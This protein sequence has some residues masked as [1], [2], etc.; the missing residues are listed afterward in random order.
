[1]TL[2]ARALTVGDAPR[3]VDIINHIISVGGSTA[4]ETPFTTDY[5]CTHY[6]DGPPVANA[7][8]SNGRVVGFQ[9]AF[10][11]APGFYSVATFTD[12]LTPCPGAGRAL[13]QKTLADCRAW[14]GE[15][16]LAKIT[17]DNTGGLA[18]YSKMGF[19]D[20]TVDPNAL[21]R[22]NGTTV[23]RVIKRFDL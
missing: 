15:A 19:K 7:V 22:Q 1:M 5:F 13:F 8:E 18:F 4:Y 21:T 12:R 10:T 9:A 6:V 16:I 20:W 14:G 11:D 23:D 3:C 17:S 2:T